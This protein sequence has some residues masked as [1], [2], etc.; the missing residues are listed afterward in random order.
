MSANPNPNDAVNADADWETWYRALGAPVSTEQAVVAILR[1]INTRLADSWR[2]G[3]PVYKAINRLE[4]VQ[5]LL[6]SGER[7]ILDIARTIWSADTR[8]GASIE[9]LGGLDRT[10]RRK[11]IIVL[12]AYY[13]G[14]DL[15]LQPVGDP[16][17]RI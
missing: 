6:S 1:C 2:D 4:G 3:E 16:A 5:H 9:S 13:L 15:P 17:V 11:I 14:R 12:V 10:N 8:N 7:A